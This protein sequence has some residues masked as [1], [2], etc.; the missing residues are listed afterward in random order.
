MEVLARAGVEPSPFAA[1]KCL[2]TASWARQKMATIIYTVRLGFHA[3]EGEVIGMDE[4]WHRK[5]DGSTVRL[6]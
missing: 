4:C 3:E 1:H 2:G 5:E 6:W